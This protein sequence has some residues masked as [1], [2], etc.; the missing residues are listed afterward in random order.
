MTNNSNR[1]T[2]LRTMASEYMAEYAL[3]L[4]ERKKRHTLPSELANIKKLEA[5]GIAYEQMADDCI[6]VFNDTGSIEPFT[7]LCKEIAKTTFQIS[8]L[9]DMASVDGIVL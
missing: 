5:L 9:K 8:Q 3:Q 2:K 4:N 7:K 1:E 6:G